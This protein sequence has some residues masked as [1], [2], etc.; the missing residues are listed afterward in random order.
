MAS[1]TQCGVVNVEGSR[2]CADCGHPVEG[3]KAV[4]LMPPPPVSIPNEALVHLKRAWAMVDHISKAADDLE[5]QIE[6]HEAE[7]DRRVDSDASFASIVF[8]GVVGDRRLSKQKATLQSDIQ[9]AHSELDRAAAVSQDAE[10]ETEAGV[11]GIPAM[12]AVLLGASG[13][14]EMIWGKP[15]IAEAY[16]QRALSTAE[17]IDHHYWLALVYE[18]ECKP[19]QALQHFERY[20][21]LDPNGEQSVSALREANAMRNYKKRFR[22]NWGTFVLLLLFWPAAIYYFIKNWK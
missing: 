22:G 12:R 9:L 21:E 11:V 15:Q 19:I 17:I 6:R 14:V 10:I 13:L 5:K 18:A 7:L 16:F 2:F 1:C 4:E 20:L 8:A 3:S